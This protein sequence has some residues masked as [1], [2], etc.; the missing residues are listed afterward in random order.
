MLSATAE[1]NQEIAYYRRGASDDSSTEQCLRNQ[2]P[3]RLTCVPDGARL[4]C[5]RRAYCCCNRSHSDAERE[6]CRPPSQVW[7]GVLLVPQLCVPDR[8]NPCSHEM[9]GGCLSLFSGSS[10]FFSGNTRTRRAETTMARVGADTHQQDGIVLHFDV[11]C[12]LH[13]QRQTIAGLETSSQRDILATVEC[14]IPPVV[15]SE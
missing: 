1:S 8:H 10:I 14:V 7:D 12:L 9:V 4:S 5:A 3:V 15:C 6:T 2:Y 11:D 13:G